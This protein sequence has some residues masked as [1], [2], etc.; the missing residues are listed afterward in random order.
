MR[1]ETLDERL[2]VYFEKTCDDRITAMLR[3]A[4]AKK[5]TAKALRRFDILEFPP[6]IRN[7]FDDSTASRNGKDE[8]DNALALADRL[9]AEADHLLEN[10]DMLLDG[11]TSDYSS[12]ASRNRNDDVI[13]MAP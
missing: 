9:D 4:L 2:S 12:Y 3:L 6:T 1:K 8:H 5:T 11:E 13:I 10:V 7:L